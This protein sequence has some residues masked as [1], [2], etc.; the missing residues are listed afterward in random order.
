MISCGMGRNSIALIIMMFERG[1]FMPVVFCDTGAEMP[2]TYEYLDY[3][4]PWLKKKYGQEIVVLS[5][6]RTPEYYTDSTRNDIYNYY[7]DKEVIPFMMSRDCTAKFKIRPKDKW[8]KENN[9]Q[10]NYM[11]I[12]A[13]ESH[14]TKGQDIKF[15]PLVESGIDLQ[16]CIDIIKG[17]GL[18]VPVKSGCFF[19]PF[20][21]INGFRALKRNH[22][23]LFKKA[24]EL[25]EISLDRR[26]REGKIFAPLLPAG[27]SLDDLDRELEL[28]PDYDT[29]DAMPCMCTL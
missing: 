14:R 22:Y 5:H 3:F 17:A 4:N 11:G 29:S 25:E 7:K 20:Q 1:Q 8:I 10:I 13:G 19:C 18:D 2:E 15:F 28:Y 27:P 12:D 26:R 6:K 16:G 24:M 21:G 23:D 9:I